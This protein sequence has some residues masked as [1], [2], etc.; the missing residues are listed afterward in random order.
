[1]TINFIKIKFV[2]NRSEQM[3]CGSKKN[4]RVKMIYSLIRAYTTTQIRCEPFKIYLLLINEV[5]MNQEVVFF[6]KIDI[7]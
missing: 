5:L 1:L 3:A 7:I 6:V 4:P 2:L